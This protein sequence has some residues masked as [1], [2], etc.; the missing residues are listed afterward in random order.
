MVRDRL[1]AALTYGGM[2]LAVLPLAW[3]AGGAC[4]CGRG[5]CPSPGKHPLI[6]GGVL[7]AAREAA[8][9][10]AWWAK[11]PQANIGIATGKASGLFVLDVDGE[12]GEASLALLEGDYGPL[13]ESWEQLTGGGG[14]HLVF[15]RPDLERVRNKVRLAPGL[16]VRGDGGYIVAEPSGHVSGGA[17]CWEAA[18]HPS[19]TAL[20]QLPPG[21]LEL[22]T[23]PGARP[24]GPA[25]IPAALPAG[26]RNNG[27]F[28]LGAS[29]RARGLSDA[30][31]AA[32]LQEE[33]KARCV[34]PLSPREVEAIAKSCCRYAPG[35][36]SILRAPATAPAQDRHAD[37]DAL[38]RL[39]GALKNLPYYDDAVIR[40]VVGLDESK[41]PAYFEALDMLRAAPGYKAREFNAAVKRYKARQRGLAL[42]E[43]G[44]GLPALDARLP[45]I[46]VKGLVLPGGWRLSDAGHIFK[47]AEGGQGGPDVVAACPHPVILAE[48]LHNVDAGTEKVRV[49]WRRDGKWQDVVA[50]AATV[51]TRTGLVQLAN[52]GLQ[53]TSESARHLV[54]FL[55]EFA[56]ANRERLPLREST[57]RLG[58]LGPARFAP[59]DKA[60]A[61]DGELSYRFAYRAVHTAGA[62]TAWLD[63]AFRLRRAPLLR[64]VL[65][66]SFAAPLVGLTGYQPFFLHLW[67]GSGAGKTVAL[68]AALSVWGDP[69][70]LIKTLNTTMVG[71]ERHAA[72]FHSLPVALDELQSLAQK[73]LPI[74]R[75]LYALSLGKSKG[76]GAAGGG[77]EQESGWRTVFLTSGEEPMARENSQGGARNR[78]LELYMDG[79]AYAPAGLGA[80]EVALALMDCYGHAGARYIPALIAETGGSREPALARWKRLRDE[81]K[82]G[83][84]TDKHV[85]SV[86]MVALGDFYASRLVFGQTDEAMAMAEAVILALDLLGRMDKAAEVDPINRAWDFVCDWVA[87]NAPRFAPFYE[88]GQPR[89]G[90]RQNGAAPDGGDAL[91][92]IPQQL[93]EAL[94]GAG[95]NPK[96]ILQ[97]FGQ[98]GYVAT[99]EEGGR[100]RYSTKA[101]V[102]G[103]RVRV[104]AFP[105]PLGRKEV[106]RIPG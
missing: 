61:Y 62:E 3:I 92:V 47:Y 98:R 95:F 17:Y 13:P 45:D 49:A 39:S 89:L 71:L 33:N 50:D 60:V 6:Q 20:A 30:A 72:F 35:D 24:R 7:N 91:F 26:Q 14:R 46:P 78:V 106:G 93:N 16:D 65:A 21:W 53:V 87:A 5:G 86:A 57:A 36:A 48:R 58:W 104:Y 38:A 19:E 74:E 9:I 84:Y 88:G 31:L 52:F 77:V 99:V 10:R 25:D 69:A 100:A 27:L 51:S 83:D 85:N 73:N 105:Y 1:E 29:M 55:S 4:S 42:V 64:A 56:T 97:G 101:Q 66:A 15:Q 79:A 2:G 23:A 68:Q 54:G 59:Y 37:G 80:G 18:H 11:W 43:P 67:G 44:A 96:K 12:E 40:L 63:L 82:D 103:Q 8:Q 34:P 102:E 75:I 94:R 28:S 81:I 90:W 41:S 22:L 32:A 76:R 70:L